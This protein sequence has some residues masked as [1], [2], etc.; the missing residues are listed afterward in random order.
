MGK[1]INFI[2]QESTGKT[3]IYKVFSKEGNLELGTIKWY[4]AWRCYTFQPK[5][6]SGRNDEPFQEDQTFQL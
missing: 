2:K 4:S 5:P 6:R 3:E 1:W